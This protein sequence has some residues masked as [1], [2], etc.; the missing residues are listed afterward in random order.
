M[1]P[2]EGAAIISTGWSESTPIGETGAFGD[3]SRLL[4]AGGLLAASILIASPPGLL[5]ARSGSI[6]PSCGAPIEQAVRRL[7]VPMYMVV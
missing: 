7:A 6:W 2:F 3:G 5:T 4:L 1:L